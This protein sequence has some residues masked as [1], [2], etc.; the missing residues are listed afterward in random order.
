MENSMRILLIEDNQDILANVREYLEMKEFAIDS[1]EDGLSG[2]HLATTGKYDLIVLDV[3]L[4]GIDGYQICKRLREDTDSAVPII[5]LT[6]RDTIDDRVHGLNAGADDYLVKPFAL[7]ELHARINALLRRARGKHSKNLC[8]G[9]LRFD[10]DTLVVSRAGHPIK[11]NPLGLKLLEILMRNSPA[12]VRRETLETAIW[13]EK[14]PES[15]SLRTHIHQLRLL[16]DKP[17]PTPLLHT[18]HGIGYRLADI[19]DAH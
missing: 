11:L 2:L 3:I 9:D 4:P 7:S 5:M 10:L 1:A 18:V 12:V 6:A 17:F 16:L 8:V 13:G 15:D 19:T 14:Y